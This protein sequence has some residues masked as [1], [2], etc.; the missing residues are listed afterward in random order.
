MY[1]SLGRVWW[2]HLD[3]PWWSHLD[4]LWCFQC[5]PEKVWSKYGPDLQVSSIHIWTWVTALTLSFLLNSGVTRPEPLTSERSG[6]PYLDCISLTGSGEPV[7]HFRPK[8]CAWVCRGDSLW[9]C[10]SAGSVSSVMSVFLQW[11]AHSCAL[12]LIAGEKKGSCRFWESPRWQ[13]MWLSGTQTEVRLIYIP[14]L[15]EC[16]WLGVCVCL[17]GFTA[18]SCQL[19]V[20][21]TIS[22]EMN[23]RL[24]VDLQRTSVFAYI[25]IRL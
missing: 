9:F 4:P 23:M 19:I 14:A 12:S 24:Q 25:L 2:S 8:C 22:F 7:S 16:V 21:F 6:N 18:P 20:G 10:C 17:C 13:V 15:R 3:P 11:H 5:G 1:N